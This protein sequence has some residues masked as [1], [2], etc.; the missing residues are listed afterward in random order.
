MFC[1]LLTSPPDQA[2][3]V[4]RM[5]SPRV[6][7]HGEAAIFDVA[8]CSK[9]IGPPDV[10][11]R[12]VVRLTTAQPQVSGRAG[13][14]AVAPTMTAAW[15]L[16]HA[17][18]GSTVAVAGSEAAALA[19][20]PIGWLG[21][22]IHLESQPRTSPAAR[23]RT[24]EYQDRLAL[25]ERWGVRTLGEFAA[26]P[27]ADILA[28]LGALGARMHQAAR[29]E[30][31]APFVPMVEPRRFEDR[32]TLEWP[33][34]GTEPL[35]F[36]LARSCERLSATLQQADRGAV[37][38]RTR[39]R[40]VTRE[41][42][43][44]ALELPTP[45]ADA[46]LL[47][48]LILLDLESHPPPAAIDVIEVDLDVSP[49]PVV[50]GSLIHP[51]LPAPEALATLMA[52]LTALMGESRVG[53]P[54]VPDTHDARVVGMAMF[55][56]P[57]EGKEG[58]RETGV[59][60]ADARGTPGAQW[61]L[62]LRR[63]RLPVAAEVAIACGAPVRVMPSA[64]GLS[65]GIVVARAGPCRSSGGWWTFGHRS[66]DRDEWDVEIAGGEVYRLTR[67]RASGRWEVEGVLD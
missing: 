45:V 63:F 33:I 13:R 52:R 59:W 44:R 25:L 5:C 1:C 10:I 43:E 37:K 28:R 48:T 27:Q 36:V 41:F 20:L 67:D 15:L 53:R 21:S 47:R 54:V 56:V 17:R 29:G 38:V 7:R 14:V 9:T 22:L 35:A 32:V 30:D 58:A 39:Y 18:P 11:L 8:G 64:R 49:G 23:L 40:L 51:T 34:E 26:L 61:P 42:H 4:A 3:A 50:Q 2:M 19:D 66:W 16:A 60:S 55:Q 57:R 62:A 31:S 65:G 6:A 24:R 46:R 12:E